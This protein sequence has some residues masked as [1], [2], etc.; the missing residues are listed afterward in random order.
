MK[1]V[2]MRRTQM[3]LKRISLVIL[4]L[5]LALLLGCSKMGNTGDG[6]LC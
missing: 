6:S 4:L 5:G 1:T 2:E 3:N